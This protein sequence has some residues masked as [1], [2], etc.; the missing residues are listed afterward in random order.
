VQQPLPPGVSGVLPG[1]FGFLLAVA[2]LLHDERVVLPSLS[3]PRP[4]KMSWDR[5]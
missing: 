3:V 4:T 1:V 5:K 2:Q